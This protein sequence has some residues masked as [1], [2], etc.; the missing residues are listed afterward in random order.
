MSV[1]EKQ[2]KSWGLKLI[3]TLLIQTRRSAISQKE[4]IIMMIS[5]EK[6]KG[7]ELGKKAFMHQNL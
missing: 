2:V 5:S 4:F 1:K 6:V 7:T 3:N